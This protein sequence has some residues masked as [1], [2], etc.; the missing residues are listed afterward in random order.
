MTAGISQ[1]PARLIE[2]VGIPHGADLV[3]FTDAVVYGL[4]LPLRQARQ[5]LVNKMGNPAMLEAAGVVA[6]FEM[7][8]R[9]ADATGIPLDA[10]IEPLTKG[11]RQQ[12][13]IDAF[14]R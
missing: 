13:G 3:R 9:I 14:Q 11:S 7:A 1:T 8:V 6:N 5:Q 4:P 10:S 2:G 12:L